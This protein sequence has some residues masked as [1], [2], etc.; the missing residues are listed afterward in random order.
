MNHSL[1]INIHP[2]PKPDDLFATL[3]S[4]KTFLKIDLSQAYQH[5]LVDEDSK[6]LLTINTHHGLYRY[7]RLDSKWKWTPACDQAIATVKEKL[8]SDLSLRLATD[9]L[10]YRV[11]AV[12]SHVFPNGLEKTY[13]FCITHPYNS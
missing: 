12:I 1:E 3:S 10:A 2:L 4:G 8:D 6:H 11:G 9:A 13:C 7:N 5:V